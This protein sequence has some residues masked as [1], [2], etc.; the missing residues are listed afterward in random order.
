[1]NKEIVSKYLLVNSEFE[2]FMR[3]CDLYDLIF[4]INNSKCK[5]VKAYA[6]HVITLDNKNFRYGIEFI[7]NDISSRMKLVSLF[8]LIANKRDCQYIITNVKDRY[9]KKR[10]EDKL[11]NLHKLT[12]R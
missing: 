11:D 5:Y 3:Y 7:T 9:I 6:T 2:Y 1:M 12:L 8:L 10:F 4:I